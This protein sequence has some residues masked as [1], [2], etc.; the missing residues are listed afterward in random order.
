[1]IAI[2]GNTRLSTI[3]K[4]NKDSIE[5]IASLSRPLEKLRNPVLRRVMAPRVTI[6]E[7][8]KIG[9][10]SPEDFRKALAA[11]G[12]QWE[13]EAPPVSDPPDMQEMAVLQRATIYRFDVR[14]MI[15][16]GKDPLASILEIY[17]DLQGNE[18]LCIINSFIPTPLIR[19]LEKEKAKVVVKTIDQEEYHTYFIPPMPD[20][21]GPVVPIAAGQ[22]F[23]HDRPVTIPADHIHTIDV[24]AL[25][26]P[27]PMQEILGALDKLP[28]GHALYV[29]HK[30]VP[31][32]LLE[33][34]SENDYQIQVT[35][36][37]AGDVRL[38]IIKTPP[39]HG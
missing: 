28:A 15:G 16:E 23:V 32:P 19:L 26:M 9:G 3:I 27:L 33:H 18:V 24:R 20:A 35:E 37:A 39:R 21:A 11:L 36:V 10:C 7:A 17:R 30:R 34:L 31:L 38:L 22:P 29:Y 25:E 8:A 12:F 13:E 1:M 6:A 2:N 5:A 4:A 14:N